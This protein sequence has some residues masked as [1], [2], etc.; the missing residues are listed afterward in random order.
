MSESLKGLLGLG[1]EG[2]GPGGCYHFDNRSP[3]GCAS[4][5]Q[6]WV[7]HPWDSL[8][9]CV[10]DQAIILSPEQGLGWGR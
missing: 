5:M 9:A 6:L 7:G 8:L 3:L 4:S 10:E 1:L 2:F